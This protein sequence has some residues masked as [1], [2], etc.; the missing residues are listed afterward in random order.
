MFVGDPLDVGIGQ[1]EPC[2]HGAHAVL[3]RLEASWSV[4]NTGS[5][6][7]SS[8]LA[9]FLRTHPKVKSRSAEVGLG[10]R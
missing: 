10:F 6:W 5:V 4:R 1:H 9:A 3:T 8:L 2:G 7:L